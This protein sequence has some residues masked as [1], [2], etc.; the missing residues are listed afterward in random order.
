MDTLL[1]LQKRLGGP[2]NNPQLLLRALTHR[3]YVNEHASPIGDNERL[4]FL[5]DAVLDY[6]TAAMLYQQYPDMK[7]G[8]LTRLRAS[9]VRAEQLAH[10]ARLLEIGPL[11]RLGKGE[12][13]SG[14]R[15]RDKLLSAALEAVV[16]A[17][18]L[19]QGIEA[20]RVVMVPLFEPLVEQ[21]LENQGLVDA[22]SRFQEW[23][24][25]NLSITPHY[26]TIDIEGPDHARQFTV[27]VFVGDSQWGEGQGRNKQIAA[28]R[29][30]EAALKRA[31]AD[32]E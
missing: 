24:Q 29:A 16:G 28:Q 5:G 25:A 1:P 26:D 14:G 19:D 18:Y 3:S 2:F 23:A 17:L 6:I 32:G 31:Q 7:E 30:A 27:G 15:T 21:V 11:L 8:R 22:K 4:E 12:R 9:L 20:V 13:A 10:V